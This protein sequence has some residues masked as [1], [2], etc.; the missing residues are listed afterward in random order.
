DPGPLAVRT[1][2]QL[3]DYAGPRPRRG[4]ALRDP[5]DAAVGGLLQRQLERLGRSRER[6][7]ED[8]AHGGGH[9]G[10]VS[11]PALDP[12]LAGQGIHDL[13]LIRADIELENHVPRSHRTPPDDP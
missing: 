11:P 12:N 9:R 10:P 4:E 2:G 3:P 13:P 1:P 7:L 8:V 6:Q 5:Y